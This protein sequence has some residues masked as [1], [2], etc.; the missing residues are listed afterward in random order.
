MKPQLILQTTREIMSET[1]VFRHYLMDSKHINELHPF[2]T[3][4]DR[5]WYLE[6]LS[7]SWVFAKKS[8]FCIDCLNSP[9]KNNDEEVLISF[10][11][12]NTLGYIEEL[13][14]ALIRGLIDSN[15]NK[16]QFYIKLNP[17]LQP[18]LKHIN[19]HASNSKINNYSGGCVEL[20]PSESILITKLEK[21]IS[22]IK[23]L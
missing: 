21:S 22:E 16:N 6:A 19:I 8:V 11:T 2:L 3:G 23:S 13:K 12:T 10:L 1:E 5:F 17:I 9:N 14:V 7:L 18:F 20:T 15:P 4:K